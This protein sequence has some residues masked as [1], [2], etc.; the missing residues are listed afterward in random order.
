MTRLCADRRVHQKCAGMPID[1]SLCSS[2]YLFHTVVSARLSDVGLFFSPHMVVGV[3][4]NSRNFAIKISPSIMVAVEVEMKPWKPSVGIGVKRVRF[5][6]VPLL[7]RQVPQRK[8]G[9]EFPH[10]L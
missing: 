7:L 5:F 1:G 8:S 2:H 3:R 6:C 10:C 9:S 4:T